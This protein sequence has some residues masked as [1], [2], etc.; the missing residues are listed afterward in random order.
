MAAAQ[1]WFA[2]QLDGI[3]GGEAR[4]YLAKRGITDKITQK[5]GIGFAPDNRGN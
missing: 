2:E 5:F 4:A 3:E 1:K